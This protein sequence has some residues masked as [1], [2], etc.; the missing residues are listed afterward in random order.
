[1]LP[2]EDCQSPA[3]RVLI[4]DDEPV[5]RRLAEVLFQK[6]GWHVT[7]LESGEQALLHLGTHRYALVVLD[8][9]M[10]GLT[11]LDVCQHIRA[12]PALR[13][14]WV[15]AYTAHAYAADQARFLAGGFDAVLV[16]PISLQDVR[17]LLQAQ[18]TA[19]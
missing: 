9:S 8:I 5:N 13:E 1:M 11:G 4:V 6:L 10:P 2:C 17:E 18:V 19:P 14:L 3:N 15:V 16:K 12:D 7:T